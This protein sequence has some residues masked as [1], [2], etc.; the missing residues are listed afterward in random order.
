MGE[1]YR[2][3]FRSPARHK[4]KT[5]PYVWNHSLVFRGAPAASRAC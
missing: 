1:V 5:D 4:I 3:D 2:L